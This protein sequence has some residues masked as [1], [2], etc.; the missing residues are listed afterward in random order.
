MGQPTGQRIAILELDP[1][2]T[3]LNSVDAALPKVRYRGLTLGP[4]G[5]LYIA[6]DAGE[7]WRVVPS[8]TSP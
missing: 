8:V 3:A 5:N 6:T 2:G 1:A 4:D 7:I